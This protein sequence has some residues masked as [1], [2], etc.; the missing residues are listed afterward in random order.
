MHHKALNTRHNLSYALTFNVACVFLPSNLGSTCAVHIDDVTAL[1]PI[2]EWH[3]EA[4]GWVVKY[5]IEICKG[6]RFAE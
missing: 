5:K 2:C 3:A 4:R 6:V 1:S